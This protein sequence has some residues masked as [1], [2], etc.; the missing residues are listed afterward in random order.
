[1]AVLLQGRRW[2]LSIEDHFRAALRA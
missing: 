1:M 2:H